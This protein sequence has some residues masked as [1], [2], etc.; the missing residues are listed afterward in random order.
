MKSLDLCLSGIFLKMKFRL[1]II[2][3]KTQMEHCVPVRTDGPQ[4]AM[5]WLGI[6]HVTMVQKWYAFSKNRSWN[7]EFGSFS[8]SNTRWPFPVMLGGRSIQSVSDLEGQQPTDSHLHPRNHLFFTLSTV[9][10]ALHEI[11]STSLSKRLCVRW[12]CPPLGSHKCSE[13]L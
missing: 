12:F 11:F 6:F 5:I 1:C 2:S 8:T 9:F 3:G 10:D 13:H 4:L 7:F